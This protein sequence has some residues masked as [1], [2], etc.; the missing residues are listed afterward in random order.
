MPSKL[1]RM[2]IP[3]IFALFVVFGEG[4]HAQADQPPDHHGSL[5]VETVWATPAEAGDRSILRLRIVNESPEH[6]HL[7]SVETPIAKGA[8]IVGRI[9][10][11]K[12][13]TLES[14]SVRADS[15]LDL[16]T[17]HAWIE[18]GP[19]TREVRA[20]DSIPLTLVFARTHIPTEAHVHDAGG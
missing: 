8:R 6:A 20:G 15:E 10:D 7:L 5:T 1:Y 11:H 2:L 14:I 13:T 9:S 17:N 12:T 19:L 4:E 18:I 16:T 3:T